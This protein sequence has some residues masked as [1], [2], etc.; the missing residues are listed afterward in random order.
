MSFDKA[1]TNIKAEYD[2]SGEAHSFELW[3]KCF[4][5]VEAGNFAPVIERNEKGEILAPNGMV[6]RLPNEDFVKVTRTPTF[7][8]WFGDWVNDPKNSSKVVYEDT[9][10][11]MVVYHGTD[12]DIPIDL[13]LDPAMSVIS[14]PYDGEV[15]YFAETFDDAKNFGSHVYECFLNIKKIMPSGQFTPWVSELQKDGYS[16]FEYN[17]SGIDTI[18]I[19][20]KEKIMLCLSDIT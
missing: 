17:F 11:P 7:K 1:P 10:E 16:G 6:S 4:A 14:F 8:A 12:K 13:G 3:D 19:F 9:G 15:L 2:R 5:E 18:G 20:D